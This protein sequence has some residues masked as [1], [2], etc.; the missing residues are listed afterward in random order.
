MA[1]SDDHYV[2]QYRRILAVLAGRQLVRVSRF[3]NELAGEF[4]P[5]E[6]KN[7]EE[8][9]VVSRI[10]FSET[11]FKAL[12]KLRLKA[13]FLDLVEGFYKENKASEQFQKLLELAAISLL[14][15]REFMT[16][17]WIEC[18]RDSFQVK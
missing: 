8:K 4:V 16:D 12:N 2:G 9:E 10:R 15:H 3:I 1:G 5:A 6:E 7:E 17:D 18:L 14:T 13:Y 11:F